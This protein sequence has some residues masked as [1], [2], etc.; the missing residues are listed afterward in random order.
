MDHLAGWQC[1]RRM[2]CIG[3]ALTGEYNAVRLDHGVD[4]ES[5]TRHPL[6]ITAVAAVDNDRRSFHAVAHMAANA[7][8]RS[9]RLRHPNLSPLMFLLALPMIAQLHQEVKAPDRRLLLSFGEIDE[10]CAIAT[11]DSSG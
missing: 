4:R 5:R 6:A 1:R 2:N 3:L 8:R 7:T 10:S 11:F 9:A